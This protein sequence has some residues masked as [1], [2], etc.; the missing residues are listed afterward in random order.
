[1]SP[2]RAPRTR[3]ANSATEEEARFASAFENV[4]TVVEAAGLTMEHV[5]Y[6]QVY[7]TDYSDEGPL[8]RVWKEYF[9]EGAA[10][11]FD[12]RRGAAAGHAG[13]D[14]RRCGEGSFAEEDRRAAGLSSQFARSRPRVVRAIGCI[15]PAF[16]G[17]TSTPA[18]SRTIP[19][20]QVEL[21]LRS[22]A[23]DA[24]GRGRWISA[25]WCS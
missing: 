11:A 1:M 9:P 10:G 8:N 22:H 21:A 17:A 3:R 2:D 5:V 24:E 12:H 6:V 7:L 23:A 16:W 25:T 14:E 15:F 19:A 13:G 20:A 4:K 18:V